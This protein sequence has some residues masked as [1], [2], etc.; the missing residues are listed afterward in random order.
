MQPLCRRLK[1]NRQDAKSAKS[2][3]TRL[4]DLR[5]GSGQPGGHALVE[6]GT[7]STPSGSSPGPRIG[8]GGGEDQTTMLG[9]GGRNWFF[10]LFPTTVIDLKDTD[11][12][13]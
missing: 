13:D 12:I 1:S 2:F 4:Y 8:R 5:S 6:G 10:T 3:E 9:E 7:V 11:A